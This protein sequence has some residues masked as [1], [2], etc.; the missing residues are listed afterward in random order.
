MLCLE[1]AWRFVIAR[2]RPMLLSLAGIVFGVA[3]FV[4]TQAQ[5]SGFEKFF[6]RTVLGTNGAIRISDQFQDTFG[7]VEKVNKDGSTEFFFHSREDALYRE[8]VK[9]PGLIREALAEFPEI[10]GASEILEGN[11]VLDTGSRKKSVEL[12]GIRWVDHLQTSD[13]SKQLIHGS[14]SDFASDQT[15]IL[16]GSRIYNRLNIKIGDRIRLIGGTGTLHLRVSGVFE[17]GVSQIDKNRAYLHFDIANSFLGRKG[18]GSIFQVSLHE[19]EKAPALAVQLQSVLNHRVVSW[20]ERE[21]VWLD[22]FQ[23][24]RVSSAITVS[25]ILLLSGLGMF[26]VFAI[27]VIEKTRD[28]AILRSMGFTPRDVS[29]IFLWQGT[30]V[31]SAGIVFGS[32]LAFGATYLI[33]IIPLRIR[34]IF[35]TDHFVVNWDLSHYLWGAA[36]AMLF[37]SIAT[38]IPARR[39]SRIEPAK[40]IRETL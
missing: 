6:I 25:C 20:Q 8:G 38:W 15:G 3:F 37:V 2:K 17:T 36:I 39:A 7:R 21:R 40:I 16:L 23:A 33:S 22:V 34:G 35:S 28:I 26:N 30:I 31:L 11:G 9:Q 19:P 27:L 12:H 4:V 10:L 24:L 18:E 1:L 32:V 5:T 13:L 14:I 29:A